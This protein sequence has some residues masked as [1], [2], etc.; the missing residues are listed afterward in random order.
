MPLALRVWNGMGLC[1]PKM[2]IVEKMIIQ[3][4]MCKTS[5]ALIPFHH[6]RYQPPANRLLVRAWLRPRA[7]FSRSIAIRPIIT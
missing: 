3:R 7:V 6:P 1:R 5:I 2:R 4:E